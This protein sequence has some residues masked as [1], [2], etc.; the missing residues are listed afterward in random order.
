M[1]SEKPNRSEI[2]ALGPVD[3]ERALLRHHREVT[4]EHRLAL[5]LTS[6]VVDELGRDEQ[7]GRV[8]HVLVF[9][10]VDRCLDLVKTGVGER[11]RHRAGEVLDGRQLVEHLFQATHRVDSCCALTAGR[12]GLA[13]ARRADQPL[14]RVG[15]HV[16][17]PRNLKRF[18][19]LGEGDSVRCSGHGV[20]S[21]TIWATLAGTSVRL[22]LAGICQDASFQHLVRLT[23][24]RAT[25]PVRRNKFCRSGWR[26]NCPDL[27]R[28]TE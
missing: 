8:G 11:Q 1:I 16:E 3:D 20:V 23:G 13:P 5:D 7:R 9:A 19:E 10:L 15:L 27:T 6:V 4:H 17:K 28:A 25:G 24:T 14:E 21:R 26:T 18:A 12:G 2:C 22:A